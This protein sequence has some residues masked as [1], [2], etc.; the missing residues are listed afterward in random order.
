MALLTTGTFV[1]KQDNTSCF[2]R[3]KWLEKAVCMTKGC[4]RLPGIA[5]AFPY[6]KII[7][8]SSVELIFFFSNLFLFCF[9]FTHGQ[10]L[11][12]F[13]NVHC[14]QNQYVILNN[15]QRGWIQREGLM[16]DSR[17]A[18]AT[19]SKRFLWIL[20][21][22]GH[23][24]GI[25]YSLS[26]VAGVL[27]ELDCAVS[28]WLYL[29]RWFY[30]LREVLISLSWRLLGW[31][32]R[33]TCNSLTSLLAW[34]SDTTENRFTMIKT[35]FLGCFHIISIAFFFTGLVPH[36]QGPLLLV[37]SLLFLSVF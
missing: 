20:L 10:Q 14:E 7:L 2:R 35:S 11:V 34:N 25:G 9:V 32:S 30:L 16:C 12:N 33:I 19:I 37:V 18:S 8:Q 5:L 6:I 22:A 27:V 4:Y 21:R 3:P 28:S 17:W 24:R 26:P 29:D 23:N 15:I 36:S 1:V 31:K 13:K